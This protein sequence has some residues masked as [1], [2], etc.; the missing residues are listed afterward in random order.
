MADRGPADGLRAFPG[1]GRVMR[2]VL[3]VD[4]VSVADARIQTMN[5]KSPRRAAAPDALGLLSRL[6]LISP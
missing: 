1:S 5:L 2:P 4:P 6:L 3:K